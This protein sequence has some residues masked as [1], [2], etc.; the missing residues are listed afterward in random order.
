MYLNII[1]PF[2]DR[3]F[4]LVFVLLF[5]WMYVI[6]A[7]LVRIKLGSPVLF[8]QKRPGM[9]DRNTGKEKI[10]KMYKYRSMT[11]ERDSEGN[12]LSDDIRLTGF[13]RKLRST[14]LDEL[15]EV[16]NILK[17]DMSFIGPRPQLVRDMVFMSDR[18]RMRHTVKPGLSGLAQV[19][20]RNSISWEEKLDWDLEYVKKISFLED[21]R[22]L[23][24]TLRSVII[25]NPEDTEITD[26][27][28]DEL[29]KM[30]KISRIMYERKNAEARSILDDL[31]YET[32]S[33][34]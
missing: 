27:Y 28:G 9:I 32:M 19:M 24:L 26:D 14:S 10:F 30:G 20:G 15:P 12:L 13:G 11:N 34:H 25:R 33:V 7:I 5:W 31:N 21:L 18:Q 23:V 1:K 3:F 4:A 2:F 8:V 16:F 22:I 6:L 17:G 29:L